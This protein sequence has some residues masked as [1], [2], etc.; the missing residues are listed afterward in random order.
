LVNSLQVQLGVNAKKSTRQFFKS[1]KRNNGKLLTNDIQNTLQHCDAWRF[2]K[3]I[4]Q[5]MEGNTAIAHLEQLF[6]DLKP[7]PES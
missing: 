6:I 3:Q 5:P 7:N 2:G 4:A 1:I